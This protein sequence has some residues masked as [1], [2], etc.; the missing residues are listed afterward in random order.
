MIHC[1]A[2][3]STSCAKVSVIM[4][5]FNHARFV[6]EGANAIL[7]QSHANLEL[8]IVDDCSTDH[9][10][11]LIQG[12]AVSDRRVRP[13]RHEQNQGASKSRN[14][15]LRVAAGEF[16]GFC[17]ADD[18]WEPQ[19]MRCQLDL[20]ENNPTSDVV[21]CDTIIVDENGLPKGRLFSEYT[22]PPK[23]PSGS[24]FRNLIRRNFINTQSVLM[25]KECVQRV[26]YFDE[27]IKWVE[28]WWYW[29]RVSRDHRFLYSP[30]PLARYRVHSQSTGFTQK[31]GY[32]INRFKVFR[33]ILRQYVD[34]PSSARAEI[35]YKMGVDLCQLGKRQ[36]G[37]RLLW[38]A[39]KM[40]MTD[41]RAFST[42][43]RAVRRMILKTCVLFS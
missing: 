31:R 11:D 40:S 13:F 14:D 21:Y 20:L 41:I 6:V 26:G 17:D 39:V 23:P 12:L 35:F 33:R 42:F 37:R 25:R 43:C 10:W 29:I 16:I 32:C 2:S 5:C 7:H 8:I 28:D 9:S 30:E 19:K 27:T 3:E 22:P 1:G 15:G 18:I 36:A 24:L 38:D 4:P 34:L